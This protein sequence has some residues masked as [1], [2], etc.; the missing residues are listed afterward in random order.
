MGIVFFFKFEVNPPSAFH[1]GVEEQGGYDCERHRYKHNEESDNNRCIKNFFDSFKHSKN[2]PYG[3]I[4][5][6]YFS[7]KFNILQVVKRNFL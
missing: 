4:G 7:V 6:I 1:V 5:H 3:K 2:S